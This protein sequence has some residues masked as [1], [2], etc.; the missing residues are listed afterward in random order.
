M[1]TGRTF[2]FGPPKILVERNSHLL[3]GSLCG[4]KG[5]SQNGI[6][7]D[8]LFVFGRIE[9]DHRLVDCDLVECVHADKLRSEKF[10]DICNR[11][12]HAFSQ[13]GGLDSVTE[14]PCFVFTR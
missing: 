14:L 13:I 1:G 9:C 8:L 3:R 6:G 11:L 4:R 5:N 2:A 10:L 7:P 12:G